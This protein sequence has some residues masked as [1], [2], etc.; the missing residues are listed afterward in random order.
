MQIRL[1]RMWTGRSGQTAQSLRL[2]TLLGLQRRRDGQEP[3]SGRSLRVP[4]QVTVPLLLVRVAEIVAAVAGAQ[5][6]RD[7]AAPAVLLMVARDVQHVATE[8]RIK[9]RPV[10]QGLQQLQAVPAGLAEAASRQCSQR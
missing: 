5:A 9:A 6:L 3:D 1:D 4:G 7:R 2:V 8:Q 10:D